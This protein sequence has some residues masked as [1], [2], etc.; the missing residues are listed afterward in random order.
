MVDEDNGDAKRRNDDAG[1]VSLFYDD[2][3]VLDTLKWTWRKLEMP[4]CW[5]RDVR[6]NGTLR[7]QLNCQQV[8]QT[9]FTFASNAVSYHSVLILSD[10]RVV[11]VCT[12]TNKS[13]YHTSFTHASCPF[14]YSW[15][16]LLVKS[17]VLSLDQPFWW[18]Q[19]MMK[20]VKE[21]IKLHKTDRFQWVSCIMVDW[22]RAGRNPIVFSLT[23]LRLCPPTH[24]RI[25]FLCKS[26]KFSYHQHPIFTLL[27]VPCT[28]CHVPCRCG[29]VVSCSVS[30]NV[31]I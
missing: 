22:R 5:N 29:D 1:E 10:T 4:S 15:S 21:I 19:V 13:M 3:Y 7:D 2:C 16:I 9:P 26:F 31:R 18:K 25:L 14:F 24:K 8:W 23:H 11:L 20:R 30:W 28:M 6:L 12:S 27:L 17:M